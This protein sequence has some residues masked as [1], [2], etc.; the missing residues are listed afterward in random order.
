MTPFADDKS[1]AV[2]GLTVENAP[3]KVVLYGSLELT[4]DQAGLQHAQA[5]R[6]L[7]DA[8]IQALQADPALPAAL[9]PPKPPRK[10]RN[11]FGP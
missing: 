10:V 1:T 6:S 5:L 9:P 11:P 8:V 4:C 2:G 7:L 3:D